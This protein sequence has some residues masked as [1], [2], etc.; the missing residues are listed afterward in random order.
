MNRTF[1][2]YYGRGD[3]GR[4]RGQAEFQEPNRLTG[5]PSRQE[6]IQWYAAGGGWGIA[7]WM[8]WGDAFG[9]FKATI[10]VQ[11]IAA[12][13]AQ[14]QASG[15]EAKGLAQQLSGW[16]SITMKLIEEAVTNRRV[17]QTNL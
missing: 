6:L 10:I 4:G 13:W 11:G 8:P 3:R 15:Q 16:A 5:L 12:R 2:L 7:K 9:S 1:V 17:E 14:R